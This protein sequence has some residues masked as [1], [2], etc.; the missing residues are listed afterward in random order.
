MATLAERLNSWFADAA[1]ADAVGRH[2]EPSTSEVAQAISEDPSHD[3]TISR[4]Y[5]TALRNGSQTNPTVNVLSAIVK[6]FQGRD[7][8]LPVSV[9]ALVNEKAPAPAVEEKDEWAAALSD[10]QVR[11]IAMRAG[12]LTPGLR[13]QLLSIMD[14]LDASKESAAG[15]DDDA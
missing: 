10:R 1:T 15:E 13:E 9:S 2:R 8:T 3:V 6:Y 4:S 12:R 14:V 5:L 11:S 7:M